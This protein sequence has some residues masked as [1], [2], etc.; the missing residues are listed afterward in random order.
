[1]YPD[2]KTENPA[3]DYVEL[4]FQTEVA[5]FALPHIVMKIKPFQDFLVGMEKKRK[6]KR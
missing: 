1:L 2:A 5:A 4:K 6:T 3:F